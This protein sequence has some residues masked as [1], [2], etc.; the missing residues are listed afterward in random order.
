MTSVCCVVQWDSRVGELGERDA[1]VNRASQEK[2][3]SGI[4]ESHAVIVSI[5]L[6]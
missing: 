3:N 4:F 5:I 2:R 6:S 1:L